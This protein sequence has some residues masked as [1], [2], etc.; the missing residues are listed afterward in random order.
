[1]ANQTIVAVNATAAQVANVNAGGTDLEPYSVTTL[2]LTDAELTTLTTGSAGV[3]VMKSTTTATQKH[4]ISKVL[5][6]GRNP[7]YSTASS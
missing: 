7:G 3:A 1:M 2:T 4:W 6:L 5:R